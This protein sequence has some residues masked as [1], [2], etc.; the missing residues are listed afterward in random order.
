MSAKRPEEGLWTE[1]RSSSNR[2]F[3]IKQNKV[4]MVAVVT[5]FI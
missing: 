5:I 3:I 4:Y 2:H 1:T